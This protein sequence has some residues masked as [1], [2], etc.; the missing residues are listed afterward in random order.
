MSVRID[1]P[2][3]YS[4]WARLAFRYTRRTIGKVPD[5]LRITAR[6]PRLLFATLV[7]EWAVARTPK[8]RPRLKMLAGLRASSLIGCPF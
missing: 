2:S 1:P 4:W 3:R 6:R 5:P 8:L 7:Y